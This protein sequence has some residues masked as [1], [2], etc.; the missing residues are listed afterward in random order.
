MRIMQKPT[1][2]ASPLLSRSSPRYRNAT[3]VRRGDHIFC[4]RKPIY[5]HIITDCPV[6]HVIVLPPA[7]HTHKTLTSRLR[8]QAYAALDGPLR[9]LNIFAETQRA[10][11]IMAAEASGARH[12]AGKPLSLLDGV[13]IGVK[14]MVS[15]RGYTM[16]DGSAYPGKTPET[17]DDEIVARLRAAGAIILGTTN[18]VEFVRN[19]YA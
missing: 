3:R 10:A 14:D 18:M 8:W 2:L 11:A 7:P 15:V 12:T 17:S 1:G 16:Q 19:L 9:H 4:P 13:P 6:F 5:S